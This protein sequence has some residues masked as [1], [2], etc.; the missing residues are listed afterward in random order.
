MMRFGIDLGGT[1]I[2]VAALASS[3]EIVLRERRPTP[4][5]DYEATVTAI[6][7]LVAGAESKLGTRGTVGVAIPGTISP[8]SGLVK[9][10]NSTALIGHPLDKDLSIALGRSVRLANDA[11]CFALSEASDGAAAGKSVVFG[12]IAG[13]GIG[14]GVV[15]NGQII[16]GAHAIAG[17]WGHNPRPARVPMRYPVRNVTAANVAASKPGA[18]GRISRR[19][20]KPRRGANSLPARSRQRR[21]AAM[22]RPRWLWSA[23]SIVSRAASPRW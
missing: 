13:T 5:G 10:A 20:S 15:V 23:G 6:R 14:G 9:N 18:P 11:N 17:E 3:G 16:T 2:E 19:N 1:K 22:R 21:K 4:R 12:V 7:D 8:K